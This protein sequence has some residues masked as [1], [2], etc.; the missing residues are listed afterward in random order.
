MN[1]TEVYFLTQQFKALQYKACKAENSAPRCTALENISPTCIYKM[2]CFT[3]L[4]SMTMFLHLCR[5]Y[6]SFTTAMSPY[7]LVI[8]SIMRILPTSD[9]TLLLQD[10]AYTTLTKRRG[11]AVNTPTLYSGGPRFDSRP[12][13]SWF[14]FLVVFLSP[15]RLMPGYYC[16]GYGS[17][18]LPSGN[19][20]KFR[21]RVLR[22]EGG[23]V[24]PHLFI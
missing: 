21:M 9:S 7:L 22:G 15:S 11:R 12:W 20:L 10:L 8:L 2:T 19:L 18:F 1:Y 5:K 24:R 23:T 6:E 4:S 16:N 17:V 14:R 13:I 3:S